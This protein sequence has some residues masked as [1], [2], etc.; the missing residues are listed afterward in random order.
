M[1]MGDKMLLKTDRIYGL[2]YAIVLDTSLVTYKCNKC[3]ARKEC[4]VKVS[5]TGIKQSN[6][7]DCAYMIYLWALNRSMEYDVE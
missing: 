4:R 2:A 6:P 1:G 3:P 5:D 7:H